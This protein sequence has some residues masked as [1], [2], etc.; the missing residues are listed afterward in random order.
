M[1]TANP[2]SSFR[3]AILYPSIKSI[4]F[5]IFIFLRSIPIPADGDRVGHRKLLKAPPFPSS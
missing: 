2:Y 1:L 4:A 3:F 5:A